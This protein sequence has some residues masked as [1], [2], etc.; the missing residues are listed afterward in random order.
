VDSLPVAQYLRPTRDPVPVARSDT[1]AGFDDFASH[2]RA[3]GIPTVYSGIFVRSSFNA[4]EVAI[5]HAEETRTAA[6]D[7]VG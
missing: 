1:P 7:A 4:E 3:L 2:A 6:P 5:R